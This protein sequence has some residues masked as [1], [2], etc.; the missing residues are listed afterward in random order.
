MP[1]NKIANGKILKSINKRLENLNTKLEVN[2]NKSEQEIL[3][4]VFNSLLLI[5]TVYEKEFVITKENK[6][7][8]SDLLS[9]SDKI[10]SFK[11]AI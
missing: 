8:L 5:K 9:I 4:K 2:K 6:K 11:K 3:K 1:K 10:I 7:E